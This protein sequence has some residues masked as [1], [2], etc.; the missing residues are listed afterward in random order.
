MWYQKYRQYV[1]SFR[2][3]A[4]GATDRQ[5]DRQTELRSLRPR[6]IQYSQKR[7]TKVSLK[8]GVH[9]H[10]SRNLTTAVVQYVPEPN[11]LS[12]MNDRDI[13]S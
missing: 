8:G 2:H 7:I 12:V 5:T 10:L 11:V 6:Y 4:R 9:I 13:L 1:L 3:I